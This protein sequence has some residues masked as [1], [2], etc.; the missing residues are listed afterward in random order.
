MAPPGERRKLNRVVSAPSVP[1]GSRK[2]THG[3]LLRSLPIAVAALLALAACGGS[4]AGT[5]DVGDTGMPTDVPQGDAAAGDT[6]EPD[7]TTSDTTATETT[8]EDTQGPDADSA[9]TTALDSSPV[10]SSAL[11]TTAPVDTTAPDDTTVPTN[12]AAC[13]VDD[14]GTLFPGPAPPSPFDP[15]PSVTACVDAKHDVAIVLGCPSN[16]D[17]TPSDCQNQRADIAKRLWDEDLADVFIVSGAAVHTAHVEADALYNLLVARG[18]PAE[19]IHKEPQA[20]H[21]DENL[22]YSTQIMEANDW[23][24]AWVVSEAAGHLLYSAVCDANCCV[25]L[26]RLT[27]FEVE[28]DGALQKIGHY[29]LAPP[30]NA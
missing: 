10:D 8:P 1:V 7:T 5:T 24:D 3:A 23:D 18:I 22:Y 16:E 26:G 29:A 13:P 15:W 12:V 25:K 4:D 17:G 9:D 21:T 14:M 6:A 2:H 19:A 20:K 30:A 27:V 11:D 28:L